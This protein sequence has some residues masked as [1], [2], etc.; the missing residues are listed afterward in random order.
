MVFGIGV[1]KIQILEQF[2]LSSWSLL[3]AV[4]RTARGA[5]D[6]PPGTKSPHRQIESSQSL[7]LDFGL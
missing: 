4:V 6:L 1:V 7:R 5:A 2:Q 3:T